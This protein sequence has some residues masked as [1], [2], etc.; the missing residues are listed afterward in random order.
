METM[1]L[2]A[3]NRSERGT[4]ACHKLRQQGLLPATV[5]GHGQEA[6][7]ITIPAKSLADLLRTAHSANVLVDLRIPGLSQELAVAAMIKEIQ[8]DPLRRVP[9]HVD[10]QWVSLTETVIVRVAIRVEGDSPGLKEGGALDQILHDVEVESLPGAI[11]DEL[12][13]DITGLGIHDSRHVSDLIA[14]PGVTI[15]DEPTDTVVTIAA[16]I[17]MAAL[18]TE[19]LEGELPEG[20]A[21][22]GAEEAGGKED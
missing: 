7:S 19:A 12:V 15:L 18:E 4:A 1:I 11:P 16:P 8:R 21:E 5:Y 2:E 20:V 13:V 6:V 9:S 10:F 3:A 14:P 22:G 17:S